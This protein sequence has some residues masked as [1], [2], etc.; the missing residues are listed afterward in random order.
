V[1]GSVDTSHWETLSFAR[2]GMLLTS[3]NLDALLVVLTG[4]ITLA[5]VGTL[6][7]V[8]ALRAA[9]NMADIK[10]HQNRDLVGHGVANLVT[11]ASGGL[12]VSAS[13]SASSTNFQAGGRT[14]ISTLS[15]SLLMVAGIVLFPGLIFS[16]PRTVLAAILV[17]VG[18]NLVDRWALNMA[19]QALVGGTRAARMQALRNIAVVVTVAL[20]TVIG[21]P[22]VGFA[23]GVALACVVFIIE[24]NRPIV[25]RRGNG[26]LLRSKRLRSSAQNA[27]LKAHGNELAV[28]QLQGLLFFGNADELANEIDRLP[29]HTKV[30]ALDFRNVTNI[31]VSGAMALQQIAAR[32]ARHG[33]RLFLCGIGER[34]MERAGPAIS[35]GLDVFPDLDAALECFEESVIAQNRDSAGGHDEIGLEATDF[36][37]TMPAADLQILASHMRRVS[38]AKGEMLCHTGDP[39]DRL[40]LLTSGS[41]SVW[42]AAGDKRRRIASIGPGCTVGEM[43]LLNDQPRSADVC[44]DDDLQAFELSA[45]ALKDILQNRP[46]VGHAILTSISRQLADRLRQATEELRLSRG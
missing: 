3:G 43:G 25:R 20:A 23:V 46:D 37:R 24:M 1:V 18:F 8:F 16:L 27:V 13:L 26:E 9:R 30:I 22:V 33:Q 21:Q 12:F 41:V 7:T 11:A 42:V 28:L 32:L 34:Q 31:D 44:A 4:S 2:I 19:R 6:D 35:K 5:L 38:F 45:T 14:R 10:V 29:K 15:A 17:Y 40:W 36:G 39:S